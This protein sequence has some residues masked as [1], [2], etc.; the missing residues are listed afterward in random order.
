MPS[1][2]TAA[3]LGIFLGFLGVHHFYLKQ[4]NV[5]VVWLLLLIFLG[6]TGLIFILGFIGFIQGISYLFWSDENW[7]KKYAL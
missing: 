1:K 5:G 4:Y 6:W 2:V 7:A 3:L